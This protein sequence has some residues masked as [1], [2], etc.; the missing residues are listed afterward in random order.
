MKSNFTDLSDTLVPRQ[1][2]DGA[3]R[4]FLMRGDELRYFHL[5]GSPGTGKTSWAEML[6]SSGQVS[7]GG[8]LLGR[9]VAW[10]FCRRTDASSLGG[11]TFLRSVAEQIARREPAFA[12]ALLRHT[13][14]RNGAHFEAHQ[15]IHNM[16]E[17]TAI[18]VYIEQLI[19]AGSS[20]RDLIE[21]SLLA[22]LRDALNGDGPLW[23]IV[24]D[25]LDEADGDIT[26]ATLRDLI[27]SMGDLPRRLRFVIT[28][29]PDRH[30]E[31]ELEMLGAVCQNIL[32]ASDHDALKTFV[33]EQA[34]K[35]RVLER[36]SDGLK[37]EQFVDLVAL[38]ADGNFLVARCAVDMLAELKGEVTHT[39]IKELP[40]KLADYYLHF[41]SRLPGDI[42][43][44][45]GAFGGRVLG[46][47]S[48]ARAPLTEA[49]LAAACGLN[50]SEVRDILMRCG[51]YLRS[52][53]NPKS[54]SI[55][56]QTFAEFLLDP[57]QA[58]EFWRP[59]AEQHQR[60]VRW[61]PTPVGKVPSWA[62]ADPYI[63]KNV[64]FH[65]AAAEMEQTTALM[66]EVLC[67][68]F[69]AARFDQ[70]N[71]SN[72]VVDDLAICIAIAGECRDVARLYYFGLLKAFLQDRAA[73]RADPSSAIITAAS[74]RVQ[75]AISLAKRENVG[76]SREKYER[77]AYFRDF[78]VQLAELGEVAEAIS[79]GETLEADI[80]ND[81]LLS[82]V[83]FLAPHDAARAVELLER[84]QHHG[85][86]QPILSV[87]CCRAIAEL[88]TGVDRALIQAGDSRE[89]LAA[90]AEGCATHDL[91]RAL[92]ITGTIASFTED[93]GGERLIIQQDNI[94][95]RVLSA[96]V[97]ANPGNG[98]SGWK[99]AEQLLGNHWPQ[100]DDI[101]LAAAFARVSAELG[102]AS[103]KRLDFWAWEHLRRTLAIIYVGAQ[104]G[105]E[106]VNALT[107]NT[108]PQIGRDP[109]GFEND[110]ELR[111]LCPALA[112]VDLNVLSQ[113]LRSQGF[114]HD[115]AFALIEGLEAD[116]E[117]PEF[118]YQ[119]ATDIGRFIALLDPSLLG[120]MADLV[121][122]SWDGEVS[123]VAA[124]IATG[125][126]ETS[127]TAFIKALKQGSFPE[128]SSH[129][130]LVAATGVIA[131]RDPE[132]ALQLV[133]SVALRYFATRAILCGIIAKEMRLQGRGGFEKLTRRLSKYPDGAHFQDA[134]I[135]IRSVVSRFDETAVSIE[136]RALVKARNLILRACEE[137]DQI[138]PLREAAAI[139]DSL[140]DA[141]GA[142]AYGE[143]IWPSDLR[144][145][146]AH[147]L[148]PHDPDFA[149][150]VALPS[151]AISLP[152]LRPIAAQ[153]LRQYL[154]IDAD[155]DVLLYVSARLRQ[156]KPAGLNLWTLMLAFALEL[157]KQLLPKL[158]SDL[159]V[160]DTEMH[161]A[162]RWAVQAQQDPV[163]VLKEIG[164]G[165]RGAFASRW[166]A[167]HA[168]INLMTT[169]PNKAL[170]IVD[171]VAP[172]FY[173][174]ES[175]RLLCA[176]HWNP[177]DWRSGLERFSSGIQAHDCR[178]VLLKGAARVDPIAALET[179][180]ESIEGSR[181]LCNVIIEASLVGDIQLK[182][183]SHLAEAA[184]SLK[185]A[186]QQED[187]FN[188]LLISAES[189]DEAIRQQVASLLL[190]A[191]STVPRM[192][193]IGC[194]AAITRAAIAADPSIRSSAEATMERLSSLLS[195]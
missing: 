29:R 137:P 74:G 152:E 24:I 138:A 141:S 104:G 111:R 191:I 60:F 119:I 52:V 146:I 122:D 130:S 7:F 73:S 145:K 175:Y 96:N 32:A 131:S 16:H 26:G 109:P 66:E 178:S 49:Q 91:E 30:L 139:V 4:D 106:L 121:N 151:S 148:I 188:A 23:I 172:D 64:L 108:K 12:Q 36:L 42:R 126:S 15:I 193:F 142:R 76:D 61:T 87:N 65:I 179:A 34:V 18:G 114:A 168:L 86:D 112:R 97:E 118:K 45:W 62:K 195:L 176:R 20:A 107:R 46:V 174:A 103:F 177:R 59:P 88:P 75:E 155:F 113:E 187:A 55:F 135:E 185:S 51:H 78:A 99:R 21:P 83:E 68:D 11:L 82:L 5:V 160:I 186:S 123:D 144:K 13:S 116:P 134:V 35:N 129:K 69:F 147:L 81:V 164:T 41:L 80:R 173:A 89:H 166:A 140:P 31:R 38:R 115:F 72:L 77:L 171:V 84:L 182:V 124:G 110:L 94:I 79:F 6:S 27:L 102:E 25:A 101:P 120:R 136:K 149:L 50:E 125:L 117:R 2:V 10:H 154:D 150:I 9:I 159:G 22:P 132:D 39:A 67:P 3:V 48:V 105:T 181:D 133:D 40:S 17:G 143:S 33:R 1:S 95:A 14:V 170:A 162:V 98:P 85:R 156:V 28:S 100:P 90:V 163:A 92:Q 47:L 58:E 192:T 190:T 63:L 153:V 157:P 180:A 167:Q 19:I 161:S 37:Q 127:T 169:D 56:H 43:A 71:L 8:Q 165:D 44:R 54:W 128:L 53:G 183:W 93:I 158:L 57:D 189:A 194:V 70:D 184:A